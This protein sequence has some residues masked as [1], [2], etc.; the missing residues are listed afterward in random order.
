MESSL[1]CI[2]TGDYFLNII[3]VSQTLRSTINKWDLLKLRNL[4]KA[5][6][7]VNK[8][9]R[10]PKGWEKFFTNPRSGRGLIYNLYK[11]L[12]N[13]GIKIPNNPIKNGV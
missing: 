9:K 5:K 7:T 6:D 12:T 2:G 1:E 10:Q 11:E 4:C 8:T 13:L 3:P